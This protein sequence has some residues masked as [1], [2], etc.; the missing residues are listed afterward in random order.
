MK[1]RFIR[2][3]YIKMGNFIITRQI[4]SLRIPIPILLPFADAAHH[5]TI[6]NSCL[7]LLHTGLQ[8]AETVGD[9][10]TE[11][12][13]VLRIDIIAPSD[14]VALRGARLVVQ[15]LV[16]R[17]VGHQAHGETVVAEE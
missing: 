10:E 16:K 4:A 14:D 11:E 9:G 6:L 17:G 13:I 3:R 2:V 8:F 12:L 1:I 15:I 5:V 7:R